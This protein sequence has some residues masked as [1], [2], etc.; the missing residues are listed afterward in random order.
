MDRAERLLT[1]APGYLLEVRPG[2]FDLDR[3]EEL[4]AAAA[5][6]DAPPEQVSALL[7]DALSCWRGPALDGLD[8]DVCRAEAA[9]L[10]ERRLALLEERIEIDLRLGR[11]ANLVAELQS[12]VRGH[13]MRE[14][15]WAQLMLALHGANRRA[16]ALAVY[17]RVRRSL[18]DQ[19]G[20]EPGA[21]LQQAQ[22]LVLAG[23]ILAE[24]GPGFLVTRSAK[25]RKTSPGRRPKP[26]GVPV[27]A[28]LPADVTGFTGREAELAELAGLTPGE[29]SVPIRVLSGTAGVGKSALAVRW[30]Q[31]SRDQ[32]ADGQLYVD[33]R[34]YDPDQPVA[35]TDALAGFLT[36]LGLSEQD[37]PADLAGRAARYRTETAGRRISVVLDNASSVQQLRP[38][39]PGTS[40][41]VVVVTSRDSLA[42]LVA[43]DGARRLEVDL[44]P[45]TDALTLLRALVGERVD[46]E[47]AAATTLV[48]QCARLPLALRVVAELVADRPT[49]GLAELVDELADQRGRLELLVAGDDPRAAVRE[50]FSWSYR[51]LPP[52]A[53]RTFRLVG[54]SGGVH[55]DAHATAALV[56]VSVGDARRTLTLL[57]HAHL[58]RAAGPDRYVM[59][60]LLRAYAAGQA[61]TEDSDQYRQASFGRHLSH[62]PTR[63]AVGA[64][65]PRGR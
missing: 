9:R 24:G 4:A 15:L 18:V 16:D 10:E 60:E 31:L 5:R 36:A 61:T 35:P 19:L 7:R 42:G 45:E 12:L 38:L 59:H 14:R 47:P 41:C 32:F 49:L 30:A 44:L 62:R 55:L 29:G 33:L 64:D 1:R 46:A 65:G 53:A 56:G 3:F 52:E 22:R 20:V 37:I 34:G 25:G 11:Y 48:E 27:P 43:L 40:A 28:Q 50:R 63:P 51:R 26:D 13:P 57:A 21:V 54:L 17:Q 8:L 23:V 58:I 6:G 39:L 2:E